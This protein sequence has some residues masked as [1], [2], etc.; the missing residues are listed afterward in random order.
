MDVT[1]TIKN[2]VSLRQYD[3]REIA[4]ED[5][6][7]ILEAVSL[8]PT[9]GNQQLYSV[10]VIKNEETKKK[11]AESCDH[12]PFIAKAPL[13]LL[14][15]ADQQKWFDY[16]RMNGCREFA[17]REEGLSWEEPNE[18]DL[19]LSVEDAMIAAQNA[20]IMAESLGIGSCYIGDILENYEYHRELFHLPRHAV[21]IS[22]LCLGYY[23]DGHRRVHRERFDRKFVVFEETY[24]RLSE[25]ELEEMFAEKAK[26]FVK[27]PAI[28]AGNFAQAFY[29]RKTGAAFSKEMARSVR[30]MLG[31]Y[32]GSAPRNQRA[33]ETRRE[34]PGEKDGRR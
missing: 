2:R 21:P 1:E 13:L 18:S 5:L 3:D 26:G 16:Y 30:V 10:I 7:K 19:I 34:M 15:V 17:E 4:G 9:A 29:K 6:D 12:Q 20:V 24:R 25:E 23:R 31:E 22:L 32:T 33:E 28:T 8:A 11:L 27:G 14:F